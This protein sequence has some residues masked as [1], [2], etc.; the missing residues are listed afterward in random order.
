[1]E[2]VHRL[3]R[4]EPAIAPADDFAARVMQVVRREAAARQPSIPFPWRLL[5]AGLALSLGL[6]LISVATDSTVPAVAAAGVDAGLAQTASWLT[7][8]LAGTTAVAWWS[9]R[10]VHR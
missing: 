5:S 8:V 4:D 2:D 7:L 1:M 6:V 3:L 9:M 10:L